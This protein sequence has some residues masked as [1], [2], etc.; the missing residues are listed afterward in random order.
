MEK[1]AL[2]IWPR[3]N[4]MMIALPNPD[5][6]YTCTLFMPFEGENSFGS[7]KTDE[8]IMEFLAHNFADSIP[9][10]P[11]VLEDYKANPVGSLVTV[12]C[13]P[14]V[15]GNF[16]LMGDSAHAV[17]PFYGQGMN[18]ALKMLQYWMI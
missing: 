13:N 5:G 18:C 4:Y 10:M 17:V 7:L 12:R 11:N 16:A 2:H 9:L 1:N 15:R 8:Q 14:W 3:G 6:S